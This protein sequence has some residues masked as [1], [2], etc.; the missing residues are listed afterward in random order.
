MERTGSVLI[1]D[2]RNS[3]NVELSTLEAGTPFLKCANSDA[4]MVLDNDHYP[5]VTSEEYGFIKAVNLYTGE[6]LTLAKESKVNPINI[7]IHIVR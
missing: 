1:I 2:D 4:C 6:I 5:E 7:E 3:L